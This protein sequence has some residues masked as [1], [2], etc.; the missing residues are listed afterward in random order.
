MREITQEDV[1]SRERER[2]YKGNCKRIEAR[3]AA[4]SSNRDDTAATGS[5]TMG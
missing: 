5:S 3:K 2:G 1:K 4:G